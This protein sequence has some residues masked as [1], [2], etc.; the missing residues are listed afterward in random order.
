MLR[1]SGRARRVGAGLGSTYV[2]GGIAQDDRIAS[3]V[4]LAV[5]RAPDPSL[6]WGGLGRPARVRSAVAVEGV[7][8]DDRIEGG[9]IVQQIGQFRPGASG[10]GAQTAA[11]PS[12]PAA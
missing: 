6:R 12:C 10:R 11:P 3:G 9:R 5:S 8:Q 1:L 4:V 7:A 2:L